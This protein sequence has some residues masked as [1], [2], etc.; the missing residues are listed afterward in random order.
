MKRPTEKDPRVLLALGARLGVAKRT[1]PRD[2][3]DALKRREPEL[4]HESKRSD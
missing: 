3:Y 2:A 4:R 1:L